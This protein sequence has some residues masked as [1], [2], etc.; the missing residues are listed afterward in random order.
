M[1]HFLNTLFVLT[2]ENKLLLDNENVLVRN[3]NTDLARFPLHTLESIISFTYAGATPALMGACAERGINL[4]F[5]SPTGKFLA[6]TSGGERGNVLLRMKQ[7]RIAESKDESCLYGRNFIVGKIYNGRWVVERALRDHPMRVPV[8]ELKELSLELQTYLKAASNCTDL[9]ELQG[10]EG[11]A[12]QCYFHGF[13]S[14]ILQQQNEFVFDSRNRRPPKD[15]VNALLSLTYSLLTRD[16]EAALESVGL[17]PYVGFIHRQRPGRCSMALDLMEEF[18]HPFADRFVLSC[19]N[20]KILQPNDFYSFESGAVML[21]DEGRKKFFSAWQK[22]KQEIL[23]H[24]FLAEKIPWGL[25]PY[26]QALLL[27]RT[28]RG[29][30]E[31]YPP[32]FWK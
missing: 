22:R 29:D 9:L 18:R 8:D 13:K 31:E 25:V 30:L 14:L 10:I 24:P 4:C 7:Y 19:I 27:A 3:G 20:Q 23:T 11:K 32:F 21:T 16:C 17:D 5:Y 1:K 6:R 26:A 12:A 15:K 28:V 2:S